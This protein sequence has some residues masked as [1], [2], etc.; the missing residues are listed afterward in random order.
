M[1]DR[2]TQF[3]YRGCGSNPI[4]LNP[5]LFECIGLD[6]VFQE[7]V[8]VNNYNP[9]SFSFFGTIDTL[10]YIYNVHS[11]SRNGFRRPVIRYFGG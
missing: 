1:V 8:I 6:V 5:L 10:T 3:C 11:V 9:P 4:A 2:G 7:S